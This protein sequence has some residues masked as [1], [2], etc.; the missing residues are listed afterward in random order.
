M[1]GFWHLADRNL[2]S[3]YLPQDQHFT[4]AHLST[5][6][7]FHPWRGRRKRTTQD[8]LV[9]EP[10]TAKAF[11]LTIPPTLIFGADDA[12][13]VARVRMLKSATR[14]GRYLVAGEGLEPPTSGL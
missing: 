10:E 3:I 7:A 2:A 5:V 9:I 14:I 11:G 6:E 1:A 4:F 12:K 13:P 8:E